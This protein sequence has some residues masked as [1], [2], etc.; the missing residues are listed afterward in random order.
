MDLLLHLK[1]VKIYVPQHW[2]A[3]TFHTA[4][5]GTTVTCA[6]NAISPPTEMH[7]TTLLGKRLTKVRDLRMAYWKGYSIPCI[8]SKFMIFFKLVPYIKLGNLQTCPA[9]TEITTEES[10]RDALGYAHDLGITLQSRKDLVSGSW[11]WVPF[12]CS[13]QAGGDQ[14]FHF[15]TMQTTAAS[16]FVNGIYHM[17]C[18]KG[19]NMKLRRN[20]SWHKKFIITF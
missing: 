18:H 9:G 3:S 4:K 2:I 20:D 7:S 11:S 1:A 10:C 5:S 15:N 13:F 19:K 8:K 17:V 12:Q 14:A 16:D 6:P